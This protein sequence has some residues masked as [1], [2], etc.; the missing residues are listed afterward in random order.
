MGYSK[1]FQET[2]WLGVACG[3][4]TVGALDEGAGLDSSFRAGLANAKHSDPSETKMQ[5]NSRTETLNLCL[6]DGCG[7]NAN[8][9]VM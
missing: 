2:F 7:C 6:V 5:A 1:L 3:L 4:A 8:A 9:M